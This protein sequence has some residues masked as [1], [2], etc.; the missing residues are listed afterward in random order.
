MKAL[1]VNT[2]TG[3]VTETTADTLAC[4]ICQHFACI[5]GIR[6]EHEKGCKFRRAATCAFPIACDHG[7]DVCPVCDPCTCS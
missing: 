5:C 7:R 4:E 3:E 6:T 1:K 2:A